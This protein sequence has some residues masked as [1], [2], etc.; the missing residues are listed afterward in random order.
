[1]TTAQGDRAHNRRFDALIAIGLFLLT[2][3]SLR[4]AVTAD[5]VDYG[6]E[7]DVWNYLLL[8][9]M[10]LPVA[11][12][13]RFPIA[14]LIVVAGA[15]VLDRGADYPITVGIW[16]IPMALHAVGTELPPH[17]S[18][19]VAWVASGLLVVFTALGAAT[20]DHVAPTTVVVMAAF[21]VFP[22]VLGREV[23]QRRTQT[24]R[25]ERR[26][27]ELERRQQ[28]Q[29]RE[30]VRR[31]RA[32]I[33]RELHDV[34]A[35]EMTVMTVQAAAARRMLDKDVDRTAGALA[36]VEHAGHAA[37]HE[38]RRLLGV[39]R[40]DDLKASHHPQPGLATL[41]E[42]VE[43]MRGAGLE[44]ELEVEGTPRSLP[45][46][47]DLNVYRI[48]QESLTNALKHGGPHTS[49]TVRIGYEPDGLSVEVLDDGRGAAEAL[50]TRPGS[51]QGHVGMRERT[52]MLNGRLTL[53]PRI[54]GGYRVAAHIPLDGS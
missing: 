17:Q 52:S 4:E 20:S 32:R 19:R 27:A 11:W 26:A 6:R 1:M 21:T 31:E 34:V 8:A 46:G 36:T 3:A 47:I 15:F 25:L 39:L 37:L 23:H 33:A 43:H 53:G 24:A 12:R 38:M 2:I 51:G 16:A 35:H 9:A 13:R 5:A 49:A 28:E 50:V 40:T 41:D 30:A 14:V 7:P 48:I 54:G 29:S 10:T 45:A 44:V 22:Y 42:L 18:R